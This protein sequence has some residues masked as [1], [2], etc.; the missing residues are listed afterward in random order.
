MLARGA[1][2]QAIASRVVDEALAAASGLVVA[3]LAGALSPGA[4]VEAVAVRAT[5]DVARALAPR[6]RPARP[7]GHR[8]RRA[9][10]G[11]R[12]ALAV[13]RSRACPSARDQ[14]RAR[15]HTPHALLARHIFVVTNQ[16]QAAWRREG[17]SNGARTRTSARARAT[18]RVIRGDPGRAGRG[19]DRRSATPPRGV[20]MRTVRRPDRGQSSGAR[21]RAGNGR[22]SRPAR[23]PRAAAR[24]RS[25]SAGW[26]GQSYLRSRSDPL[27]V[28]AWTGRT[29]S[30]V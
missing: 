19:A 7:C 14:P 21:H 20:R 22:G 27:H 11:R 12:P 18:P 17:R 24:S 16:D 1:R 29:S 5:A 30:A 10:A 4:D 13:L 3:Y 28:S 26:K 23:L 8:R 6:P 9:C 15:T 2:D 25:S